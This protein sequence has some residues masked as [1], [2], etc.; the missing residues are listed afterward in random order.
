MQPDAQRFHRPT[1]FLTTQARNPHTTLH[2]SSSAAA[3][4]C[5]TS[6][7]RHAAAFARTVPFADISIWR[8]ADL[9][10]R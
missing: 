5:S 7:V 10:A 8:A 9:T 6:G 1:H 4:L 3:A 2:P